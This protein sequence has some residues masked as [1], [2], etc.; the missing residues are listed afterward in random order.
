ME[1][2]R[3]IGP[4]FFLL[5]PTNVGAAGFVFDEIGRD[6]FAAGFCQAV[7]I[8]DGSFLLASFDICSSSGV[9]IESEVWPYRVAMLNFDLISSLS[10][11]HQRKMASFSQNH[12][13]ILPSFEAVYAV[14][15][16]SSGKKCIRLVVFCIN[17]GLDFWKGLC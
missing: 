4:G 5:E 15:F 3:S 10:T 1:W 13:E 6:A 9:N 11:R 17:D 12:V 2:I 14:L 16:I 7:L 8:F